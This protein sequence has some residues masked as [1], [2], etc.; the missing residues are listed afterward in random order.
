MK[1]GNHSHGQQ[2][3]AEDDGRATID[4]LPL[5]HGLDGSVAEQLKQIS[6]VSNF[7]P[8]ENICEQG[9][10]A[11]DLFFVLTGRVALIHTASNGESVVVEVIQD[12]GYFGL[13]PVLAN[14]PYLATA[15]AVVA[16]RLALVSGVGLSDLIHFA[17]NLLMRV[18]RAEALDFVA[19]VQQ[20]C[21][22]KFRTTSQRLARYLLNLVVSDGN[23]ADFRLPFDKRLLAAKIG[24]RQE[25][26][27]RAFASLRAEGV[28]THG[29]SVTLHDIQKLKRFAITESVAL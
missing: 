11:A 28:E 6:R 23:T 22:L 24:C 26:L 2:G 1:S 21:D 8:G 18:L 10:P 14:L 3:L 17:P 4:V 15:K 20:V 13:A 29:S 5:F 16:S 27:S 9:Q 12:G 25:N 19:V 7:L